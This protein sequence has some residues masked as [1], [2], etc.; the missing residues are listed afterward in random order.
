[1]QLYVICGFMF[2]GASIAG[3]DASLMG[4]LLEMHFFPSQF[5]AKLIGIKAGIISSMYSIGAVSGL[6]FVGLCADNW[7]RRVGIALGCVFIIM[8]TIIQG[9][10]LQLPQYLAGRIFLVFGATIASVC[11]AYIAEIAHPIYRGSMTGLYNCFYYI[12]AVL[13]AAVL[14]GCLGYPSNKSWLIPTWFQM[15][16]PAVLPQ[17]LPFFPASP[18]WQ[19]SNGHTVNCRAALVKYHGNG[20]PDSLYVRVQMREFEEELDL[21]VEDNR[22]WDYRTLFN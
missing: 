2:L 18:R 12:G 7:G 4:N 10:S 11:P 15:V 19:F 5:G 16:L 21:N 22:W 17:S 20:N 14:R 6:P 9:T 3:Y 1:M 8:G 13:A